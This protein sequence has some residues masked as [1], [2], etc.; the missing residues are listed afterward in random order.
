MHVR[1]YYPDVVK[2]GQLLSSGSVAE[3]SKVLV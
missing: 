3:R 2:C 1:K